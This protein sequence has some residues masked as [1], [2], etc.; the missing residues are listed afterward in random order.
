MEP[1]SLWFLVRNDPHARALIL[2]SD[3]D[4]RTAIIWV[5]RVVK[6]TSRPSEHE[7]SAHTHV[8]T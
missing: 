1:S 3:I 4:N 5:T 6:A 8:Q 2:S 7:K